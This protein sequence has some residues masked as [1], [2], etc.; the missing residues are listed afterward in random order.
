MPL[1]LNS[2]EF[3][4]YHARLAERFR[5]AVM[6][7]VM[8]GAQRAVAYLV[9][10]TRAAPPANPSGIGTGG[11]VDTGNLVRSWKAVQMPDGATLVNV[12]GYSPIVED[13]RRAGSKMP[14]RAALVAWIRRKIRASPPT[15]KASSKRDSFDERVKERARE[16]KA[17]KSKRR[18]SQDAADALYFPIAR[19]IARRGLRARRILNADEARRWILELVTREVANELNREMAKR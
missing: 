14:P 13:G 3:A 1:I 17:A 10:R 7:G 6:R 19:A 12:A 16:A 15:R 8:S 5:P 18:L 11:A 4:R 9:E 2:K